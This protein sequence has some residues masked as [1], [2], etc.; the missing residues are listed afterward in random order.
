MSM[1]SNS[2]GE[3]HLAVVPKLTMNNSKEFLSTA[4]LR[5]SPSSKLSKG[6]FGGVVKQPKTSRK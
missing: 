4:L 5:Y 1:G 6:T 2:E 3:V